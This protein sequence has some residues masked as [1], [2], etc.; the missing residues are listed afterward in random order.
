MVKKLKENKM[1]VISIIAILFIPILYAGNFISAFADPYNRMSQV[2]VAIVND[3][4]TITYEGDK[5]NIGADFIKE[6]KKS[7]KFKWHFV[8]DKEALNGMKSNKYYFTVKIPESLTDNVYSTLNGNPKDAKLIY[9]VNDNKNYISGVLGGVLADELNSELNKQIISQFV[10]TLGTNLDA[11]KELSTGVTSLLDGSTE[12]TTGLNS[13]ASGADTLANNTA[14]LSDETN[15]LASGVSALN[16]GYATFD[17]SLGTVSSSLSLVSNGYGSLNTSL[18]QYKVAL[19]TALNASG[20]PSEQKTALLTNYQQIAMTSNMLNGKLQLLSNGTKDLATNSKT[21]S[22]NLN[23]INSGSATISSYLTQLK[24]GAQSLASGSRRLYSGS[25]DLK[26]GLV[27]L[28]TGVNDLNS[29]IGKLN[30]VSNADKLA[31]PVARQNV[32]YSE[33]KNYGYGFA[34]YFVSL[35][36]FVGALVTTIV[37]AMKDKKTKQ[38]AGIKHSLKKVGIFAGVVVTQ[39]LIL[40]AILLTTQIQIDNVMLFVTF[41]ILISLMFMAIIQMFSTLFGDAGRFVSI[42]L[43][44]LQLT[45]CGGTFPVETSPSFYN[46]I[47]SFMPMTYTV[48]GLRVIIGNGNMAILGNAVIISISIILVCYGITILYFMKSRKYA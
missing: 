4:K 46:A 12:L 18:A 17:A 6:I 14:K 2:D 30:L 47:H 20:L 42:I 32:P 8:S 9:M 39:A 43:L 10:T 48:D 44:I 40:D 33:V 26:N 7:D 5:V 31:Q 34:P 19:E 16:S 22:S 15:N 11:A 38:N 45:A 23:T 35:G 37:L 1:F 27:T 29:S 24:G 13:L 28:N 21:I 25:S 3:D 36:L 41:S